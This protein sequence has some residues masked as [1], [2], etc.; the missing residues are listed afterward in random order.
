ME[1]KGVNHVYDIDIIS[2]DI[3]QR[4]EYELILCGKFEVKEKDGRCFVVR[5]KFKYPKSYEECCEVLGFNDKWGKG[6]N[7]YSIYGY[8]S[9]KLRT[10]QKLLLCRD[11]YWKIA[12]EEMGLG[13][14]WKADWIEDSIKY[15]IYEV[16]HQIRT[17]CFSYGKQLLAFP[18]LEMRDAFYE[19]FKKQINEVKELL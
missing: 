7:E 14:P 11:A 4:D 10:F 3:A 5:K 17:C 18:T 9:D 6:D 8:M 2:F 19:N 13:K 15:V 1:N 16:Y 12:G